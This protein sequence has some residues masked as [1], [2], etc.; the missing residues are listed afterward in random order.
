MPRVIDTARLNKEEGFSKSITIPN[1]SVLT[2]NS[3][4]YTLVA[5]PVNVICALCVQEIFVRITTGTAYSSIHDMTIAYGVPTSQGVTICNIPA[6]G[7]LDQTIPTGVWANFN[8]TGNKGSIVTQSSG[9]ISISMGTN[10]PI[11]GTSPLTVK[12]KYK[13][14]RIP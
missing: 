8:G 1:S 4:G 14:H 2:L 3:V 10:D 6:I 13:I 5:S 7:F 12:V 11:L 9:P